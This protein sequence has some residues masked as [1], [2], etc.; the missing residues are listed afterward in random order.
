M[1]P[2]LI[3]IN[4]NTTRVLKNRLKYI[5]FQVLTVFSGNKFDDNLIIKG[6][7]CIWTTKNLVPLHIKFTKFISGHYSPPTCASD[8]GTAYGELDRKIS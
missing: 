7:V 3:R 6:L 1:I 5:L 8:N 4:E 2:K